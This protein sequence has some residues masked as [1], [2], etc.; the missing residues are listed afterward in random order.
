MTGAGQAWLD[1]FAADPTG[2]RAPDAMLG[3]ASVLEAQ[4][5]NRDACG[6]LADLAIRFPD[7]AAAAETTARQA[8]LGCDGG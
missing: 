8:K 1:A 4:G 3:I 2:P 5:K 6:F 7:S